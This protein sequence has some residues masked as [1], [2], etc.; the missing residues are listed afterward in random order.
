MTIALVATLIILAIGWAG[1]MLISL[2]YLLGVA[3]PLVALVV[4]VG[5]F[6]WKVVYWAKSPVPF[7]IPTTG[8]QQRSLDWIKPA[9]LDNPWTMPAVIGRMALEVLTFRSLF[10][11]TTAER[12][13]IN[14]V[15]RITYYSSKWLWVFALA[16][17]YS[18]LVILIRHGRFFLEPVPVALSIVEFLDGMFQIGTPRFYL[19]DALILFGLG[20]LFL[21]RIFSE[22]LRYLSL[23][24][25]YFAL[26]LLLSV[27]CSGIW[28]RYLSKA[29]IATVKTFI[30][31]FSDFCPFMPAEGLP[32]VFLIHL[33]FVCA[34]LIYFPF[35]KLMHM[36][37]VFMSPTR[38]MKADTRAERH[39]NPWNPPK[40]YRT[41]AEYE[42]DYRD[43][44]AEAGLPLEKQPQPDEDAQTA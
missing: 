37:G 21:R 29:D 5:G 41:Y 20:M 44:M 1:S 12:T 25:D 27:V 10:R 8:G 4:F 17:H 15:P 39:I 24:A 26:F 11:N 38:N 42:D 6:V 23:P 2:Q 28:M 33:T 13:T 30:M 40:K 43:A 3:L 35:S 32:S 19:T 22:R 18:M 14:G 9:R 7:A 16:F 31:D 36:G 34:L